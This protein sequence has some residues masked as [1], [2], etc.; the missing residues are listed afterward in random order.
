MTMKMGKV[1]IW[2]MPFCPKALSPMDL[3]L[4]W[5]KP[6]IMMSSTSWMKICIRGTVKI[7][8]IPPHKSISLWFSEFFSQVGSWIKT[9]I[10]ASKIV[11]RNWFQVSRES[12]REPTCRENWFHQPKVFQK[13]LYPHVPFLSSFYFLC[14]FSRPW[15]VIP[16]F[17]YTIVTTWV[18][19]VSGR[20]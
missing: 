7:V 18:P 16:I 19:L 2:V 4:D 8:L 10:F 5:L 17:Y 3:L 1:N 15:R 11:T 6:L 20:P 12:C 14:H 13:E 9:S